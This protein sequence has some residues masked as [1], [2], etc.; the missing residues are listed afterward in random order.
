[1]CKLSILVQRLQ[2]QAWRDAVREGRIHRHTDTQTHRH[3][4]WSWKLF[5]GEA[6]APRKLVVLIILD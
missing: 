3:K 6:I 5:N 4:S 2:A 1:M